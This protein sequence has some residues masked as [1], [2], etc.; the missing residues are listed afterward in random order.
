[1]SYC[2]LIAPG[3][4]RDPSNNVS[5][6]KDQLYTKLILASAPKM[7]PCLLSVYL[8]RVFTGK[9]LIFCLIWSF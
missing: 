7:L 6:Y 2:C 5:Q 4:D 8:K 3:E 9:S 1:M